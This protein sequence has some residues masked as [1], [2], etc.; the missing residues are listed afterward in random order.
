MKLKDFARSEIQE[1]RLMINDTKNE[2][3]KIIKESSKINFNKLKEG[4]IDNI[5]SRDRKF[6]MKIIIILALVIFYPFFSIWILS[7]AV[8][9]YILARLLIDISDKKKERKIKEIKKEKTNQF[10]REA[11]ISQR[12]INL[13]IKFRDAFV[14][15]K[16]VVI[17]SLKDGLMIKDPQSKMSFFYPWYRI[18]FDDL[19]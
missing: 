16:V 7:T 1:I 13:P 12:E 8:T 15:K 2:V 9:V 19:S 10:I 18:K 3:Y 11:I 4:F 6:Y 17:K 14:T 5:K